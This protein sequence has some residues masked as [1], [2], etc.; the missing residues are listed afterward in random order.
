M[1]IDEYFYRAPTEEESN[2]IYK[3][4]KKMCQRQFYILIFFF[5]IISIATT[6]IG[7]KSVR[8]EKTKLEMQTQNQLQ[9]SESSY[10]SYR[11]SAIEQLYGRRED[12]AKSKAGAPNDYDKY[13]DQEATNKQGKI[14]FNRK[15]YKK[16]YKVTSKNPCQNP[17]NMVK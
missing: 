8:D 6:F 9:E 11:Q 12:Y 14:V 10:D 15:K 4:E 5:V 2:I 17:K 3:E 16:E 7:I 13:F 1:L